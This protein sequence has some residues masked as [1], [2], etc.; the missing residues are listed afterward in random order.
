MRLKQPTWIEEL[1]GKRQ[2]YGLSQNKLAIASGITRQYLSDIETGK[3]IPTSQVKEALLES[4]E[5]FN[6]DNPLE[7]LFDYVRIRF[8]TDNVESV[9]HD[10]L[11]LNIDYMIHE[12]FGYYSY[13]EHYRFGDVMVLCSHALTKGVLLELKGKGCRQFES[14]LLAQHRSWY[15]FFTECLNM[16]AVFKRIDLAINDKVGILDIPELARKCKQ[17]ECISVFRSF[18]NYRSGELVHRDEKPDMGNTLY[19][20]SLKSEVYFCIYEKD[21]EQYV[22]NDI[23]FEEAEV[24]NRFEIRLKNERASKAIEDLL[25]HQ[26]AERTAFQ[27]I[28]RYLR[29]ADKDDTKRR[30]DWQ[31]NE[32]WEW[33]IGKNRGELRLT[34][35]PEPYN[36]ERTLNWLR[37]QVAPTLKVVSI[38]DVLN[39]TKVL[40]DMIKE[41]KLTDKH[42]KLIEQQ[43]LAVEDVIV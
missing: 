26:N 15:D 1:K 19:I 29:F 8:P 32:R 22:K 17:E 34:T 25:Q 30:S 2:T 21:Y 43:N 9:I 31:T 35:K 20:G 6:P 39:E 4:L 13:P 7:L 18:K 41:T 5:R 33:F 14:Y 24:K 3:V 23:P 11:R 38:L 27:I 28:N 40:P 10:I 36:Y 37:H 42:E 16:K 12:D